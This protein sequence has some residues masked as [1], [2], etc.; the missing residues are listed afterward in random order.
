M[1][2][3]R[4]VAAVKRSTGA[5]AG[6][7]GT[8]DPLATGVLPIALGEA[9]KTVRF[10]I[11]RQ[12]ALP[13]SRCAGAI[14]T[15]TDDREGSVLG[16]S[17]RA[18]GSGR[19][20]GGAAAV[21]RHRSCSGRRPIPRSRSPAAAPMS[22][23]APAG[24]PTSPPAAGRDRR[25]D[26]RFG[27]ARSAITPNSRRWSAKAPISARLPATWRGA[28]H[29]RPCRRAAPPRGRPLHRGSGDF[30]GFGSGAW[31]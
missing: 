4:V 3:A 14:A 12:Q 29:A 10:A 1:T 11:G 21:H 2:S 9:T 13:L 19:D 26:P 8:L 28:R 25:A 22:W 24:R 17:R 23:R 5:K 31:A 7:A 27:D 30:A 16:E 6:H 18:P 15:D 20:R